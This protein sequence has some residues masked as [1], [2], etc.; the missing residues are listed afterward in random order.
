M[1][2]QVGIPAW[3]WLQQCTTEDPLWEIL[4][5][6]VKGRGKIIG[7]SWVK[8]KDIWMG[9]SRAQVTFRKPQNMLDIQEICYDLY[10]HLEIPG[11]DWIAFPL[12][13]YKNP[14]KSL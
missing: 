10:S 13:H 14:I 2:Q 7:S 11:G 5:E 6:M 9:L 4:P 8:L 1:N 12:N 3:Q